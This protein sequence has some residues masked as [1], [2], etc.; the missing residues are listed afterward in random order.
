MVLA[1]ILINAVDIFDAIL[2]LC[3]IKREEILRRLWL[4]AWLWLWLGL[5]LWL[6]LCLRLIGKI[7]SLNS[8]GT[9]LRW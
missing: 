1:A 7:V 5:R 2:A 4:F 8:G 6:G 9:D 3:A